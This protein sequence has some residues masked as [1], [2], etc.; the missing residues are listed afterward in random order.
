MKLSDLLGDTFFTNGLHHSPSNTLCPDLADQNY[1]DWT[2]CGLR[3]VP[4]EELCLL[5]SSTRSPNLPEDES[6]GYATSDRF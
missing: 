5:V 3:A 6:L 2:K 4:R 1:K